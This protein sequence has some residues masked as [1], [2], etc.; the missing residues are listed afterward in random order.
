[1][2]LGPANLPSAVTSTTIA[3]PQGNF[4]GI[5]L[6]GAATTYGATAQPFRITYTDGT[7]AITNISLSP[8]TVSLAYPGETMVALNTYQIMA[9]EA[10]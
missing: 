1:L 7:T 2:P 10:K 5:S 9:A 6:I 4:A 3:L 8:W